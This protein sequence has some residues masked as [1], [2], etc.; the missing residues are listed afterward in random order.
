MTTGAAVAVA[1][2]RESSS[3]ASSP[4]A[5][6]SA[7]DRSDQSSETPDESFG[8]PG[9]VAPFNPQYQDGLAARLQS[10]QRSLNIAQDAYNQG[11][12][13]QQRQM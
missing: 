1:M 2:I 12:A 4:E 10:L 7:G 13:Y 9:P 3:D 6:V 11:V 8:H 5:F